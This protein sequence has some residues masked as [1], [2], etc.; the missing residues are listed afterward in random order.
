[1]LREE[2]NSGNVIVEHW[3]PQARALT[4]PRDGSTCKAEIAN[5]GAAQYAFVDEFAEAGQKKFFIRRW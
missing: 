1:M 5:T 2:N 3:P 4:L